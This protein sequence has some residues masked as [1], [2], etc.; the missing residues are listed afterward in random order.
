MRIRRR[1]VGLWLAIA[2]LVGLAAGL[3]PTGFLGESHSRPQPTALGSAL[4][5]P[6]IDP[7]RLRGDVE[8]L[9]FVRYEAGDRQR[10]AEYIERSLTAAG[11]Q[12][13][14]QPFGT[15]ETAGENLI[16]TRPDAPPDRPKLL[17]AAHYDT[18]KDSPGADDNATA[19]ATVLEAARLLDSQDT[20]CALELVLFDREEAGLEGS[21]AFVAD[22][23]RRQGVRGAVV[24]DMIGYGCDLAGCQ[25]YPAMLPIAPPT[26]RGNFLAV[27]GDL[28]RNPYGNRPHPDLIQA[29]HQIADASS[30]DVTP[31][32]S[33]AV[34]LLGDLTPDLLRSDHT[35]FWKAGIGAVLLTDTANFRNP[36][37]HQPSDTPDT[38]NAPFFLGSA[39]LVVKA[40]DWLLHEGDSQA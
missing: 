39:R 32:L 34:P 8:A 17:L 9:S 2:L 25:S 18:V 13:A 26:D 10:A 4:T 16:A 1:W 29:F 21:E 37:Y 40:V 33:L 12:V 19:V 30:A 23:A 14:R 15:G 7:A 11:W 20:P 5:T 3:L 22:A 35:P 31:V 27:I 6:D 38:L 36:H 24:M 28:Q